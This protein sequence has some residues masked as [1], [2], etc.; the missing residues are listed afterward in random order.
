[1]DDCGGAAADALRC[2]TGPPTGDNARDARKASRQCEVRAAVCARP[3]F[4]RR[5]LAQ[6][7]ILDSAE[8]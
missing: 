4:R 3:T 2:R 8:R 5:T 6:G 7:V 1:M